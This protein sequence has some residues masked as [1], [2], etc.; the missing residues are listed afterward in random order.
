VH[1]VHR[2][3]SQQLALQVEEV[4]K[5]FDPV[6]LKDSVLVLLRLSLEL[7]SK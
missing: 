5:V 2:L 4:P 1:V 7:L 3:Q 6:I